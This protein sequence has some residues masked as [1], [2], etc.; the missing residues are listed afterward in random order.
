MG[1][2]TALSLSPACPLARTTC[3][4]HHLGNSYF[5]AIKLSSVTLCFDAPRVR[6]E[7]GIRNKEEGATPY[8]PNYPITRF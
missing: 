4:Y 5:E 6:E 8:S 3:D 2:R 7:R 1:K